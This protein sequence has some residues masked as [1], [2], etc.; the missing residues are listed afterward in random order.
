MAQWLIL[1]NAGTLGIT[2][3]CIGILLGDSLRLT[4]CLCN[5]P[6]VVAAF[7][8]KTHLRPLVSVP[9]SEAIR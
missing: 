7:R 4:R 5:V 2:V 6:L 8:L 9:N 1:L 3:L